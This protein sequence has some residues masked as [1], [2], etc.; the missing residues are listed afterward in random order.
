MIC[1][2]GSMM[3]TTVKDEKLIYSG[4]FYSDV[5]QEVPRFLKQNKENID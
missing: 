3:L 5:T 1:F 4:R 2:Y